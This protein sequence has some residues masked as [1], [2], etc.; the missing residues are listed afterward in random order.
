[1]NKTKTTTTNVNYTFKRV[2]VSPE[3]V[4]CEDAVEN[5]C[6]SIKKLISSIRNTLDEV[7]ATDTTGQVKQMYL[8][9]LNKTIS[10]ALEDVE[11]LI[12][13]NNVTN[14]QEIIVLKSKVTDLMDD[15]LILM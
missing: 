14:K 15:V 3:Y 12:E 5:I 2:E 8:D 13:K 4:M 10:I 1:M 6:F 11:K 9:S 7:V